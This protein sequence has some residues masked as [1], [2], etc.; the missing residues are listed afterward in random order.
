[1]ETFTWEVGVALLSPTLV[2]SLSTCLIEGVLAG[3]SIHFSASGGEAELEWAPL[4]RGDSF[5]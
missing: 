1:M 4:L 3:F 5:M 2:S